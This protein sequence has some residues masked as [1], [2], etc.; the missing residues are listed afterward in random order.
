MLWNFSLFSSKFSI[1]ILQWIPMSLGKKISHPNSFCQLGCYKNTLQVGWL[2]NNRHFFLAVLETGSA[3]TGCQYGQ[4]RLPW[5]L[6]GKKLPAM[7]EQLETW[8]RSLGQEDPLEEGMTT[9]S[10]ILAWRIPWIEEP[11]GLHSLGSQ[12]V[13]H[14]WSDF[15]LMHG[16]SDEGLLLSQTSYCT[17]TWQKRLG[18]SMVFFCL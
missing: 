10:S 3:R 14:D 13:G 2:V 11:S 5:W 4:M 17:F 16:M 15:A 8:L 9:H 6:S 12:R 7:Q 1:K 18:S